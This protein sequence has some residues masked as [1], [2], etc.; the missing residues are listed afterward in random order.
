MTTLA[1]S[2]G[3]VAAKP[4]ER[5]AVAGRER[6]LRS[7]LLLPRPGDTS[8]WAIIP[9]GFLLAVLATGSG[10]WMLF[11]QA[12]LVW[13]V[14]EYL[15]YQARYQWN[16]VRGFASDQAHPDRQSRGRLPGPMELGRRNRTL[17]IVV[18]LARLA[19]AAGII[20]LLSPRSTPVAGI[21]A[22]AVLIVALGYE[23]LR[24]VA[25]VPGQARTAVRTRPVVLALWLVSGL[26]YLV[27]GLTGLAL[28]VDLHRH[29][30][31]GLV[32]GCALWA[33]GVGFVTARWAVE[34]I[35]FG[36]PAD[37]RISWTAT[38][39]QARE[40]LLALAR[41]L[42]LPDRPPA[43][44][45]GLRRWRALRHGSSPTAPWN[46]AMLLTLPLSAAGGVQL[47]GIRAAGTLA[48]A[49]AAGLLLAAGLI[50]R[51]RWSIAAAGL[52]ALAIT[53]SVMGVPRCWFA[54]L[55]PLLASA[56]YLCS[57]RQCLAEIG[58]PVDALRR[59]A[60]LGR[61]V[62]DGGR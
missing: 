56:L 19:A 8:K 22:A 7:Y 52:A 49:A 42:P 44:R 31:L 12:V 58:K 10:S 23:T 37:G 57:M 15:V 11:G 14:I 6:T 62:G 40:H 51:P 45:S 50:L 3:Q 38:P 41:W 18:A 53:E 28:A 34:S 29:W 2:T 1:A 59:L 13:L 25:A 43:D 47:I 5:L 46:L 26:G 24:S 39:E 36:R 33:G 32:A 35:A 55:P 16:D 17:S 48:V 30:Q 4:A 9:A 60:R 27:R 61:P 21:A 54:V 20:L